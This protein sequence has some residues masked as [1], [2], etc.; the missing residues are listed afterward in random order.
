MAK[1]YIH[2]INILCDELCIKLSK[3]VVKISR[4]VIDNLGNFISIKII[5]YY[6]TKKRTYSVFVIIGE[7]LQKLNC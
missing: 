5:N 2:I 4:F 3:Y 7:I 1:S 6:I